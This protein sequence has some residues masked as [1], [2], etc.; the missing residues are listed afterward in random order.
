MKKWTFL[1]IPLLFVLFIL[2]GIF[3]KTM[4]QAASMPLT[5]DSDQLSFHDAPHYN[6]A[7]IIIKSPIVTQ[8]L[9]PQANYQYTYAPS[10]EGEVQK[11]YVA[12]VNPYLPN[13]IDLIDEKFHGYT[14]IE[15]EEEF[16]L[17]IAYS[18]VFFFSLSYPMIQQ[19]ATIDTDYGFES[20]YETEV[21]V[22]S[23]SMTLTTKAGT[24]ENVV[25]IRYPNGSKLY[26]AKGFGI[27]R[28]TDFDG[29]ITTELISRK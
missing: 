5:N 10:F 9:L 13:A 22:E 24:F 26:L 7:N 21:M 25:V 11:T 16:E 3:H 4:S 29:E 12:S 6:T 14:Y 1:C 18:D 8:G 23:T 28:I 27:I 19:T 17:G 15:S 2:T 20:N